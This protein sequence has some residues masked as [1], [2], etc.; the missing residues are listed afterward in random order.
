MC[1]EH[2]KNH[3]GMSKKVSHIDAWGLAKKFFNCRQL[4]G[5]AEKMSRYRGS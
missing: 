2:I 1:I 3:T 5:K 4:L